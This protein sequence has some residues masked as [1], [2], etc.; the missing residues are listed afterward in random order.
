MAVITAA[1]AAGAKLKLRSP[2]PLKWT[3]S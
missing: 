1:G 3:A 2:S